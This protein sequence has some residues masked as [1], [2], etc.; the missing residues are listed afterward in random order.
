MAVLRDDGLVTAY[1][2]YQELQL[3]KVRFRLISGIVE[4]F[5]PVSHIC[6]ELLYFDRQ[7]QERGPGPASRVALGR[8]HVQP[9]YELAGAAWR[10]L[11][12]E[13][14]LAF[15]NHVTGLEPA[16]F[17][18]L[19]ARDDVFHLAGSFVARIGPGIGPFILPLHRRGLNGRE[20]ASAGIRN[21]VLNKVDSI[22][23]P[24]SADYQA[25]RQNL[26]MLSHAA[27]LIANGGGVHVFPS[28]SMLAEAIWQPGIGHLVRQLAQRARGGSR[29]VY[30][31][32]LVYGV[33]DA[34]VVAS[35]LYPRR[36]VLR[37]ASRLQ[38]ALSLGP[39]YVYAPP[40]INLA[41]LGIDART[42]ANAITARLFELWTRAQADARHTIVRWPKVAPHLRPVTSET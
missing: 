26:A 42:P 33:C 34:H 20:A 14:F 24:P 3:S 29:P 40:P 1:E 4:I 5:L 27:D 6:R 19:L 38:V 12:D 32:P 2:A 39:P 17:S 11:A 25:S 35:R 21:R 18:A 41:D 22:V 15:G 7:V 23:W 16:L 37:L 10:V 9:R 31:V 8:W 30:L 13:P 28:G 36:S